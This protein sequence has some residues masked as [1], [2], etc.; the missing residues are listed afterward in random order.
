ME[1]IIITPLYQ[2]TYHIEWLEIRTPIGSFVIQPGHAPTVLVLMPQQK[3]TFGLLPSG[4]RESLMIQQ[5]TV[6]IT[7]TCAT[8]LLNERA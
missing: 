3:V 2:Q 5:G 1:L 7:R 8:L 6:H 4:K